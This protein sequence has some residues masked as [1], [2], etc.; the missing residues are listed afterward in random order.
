MSRIRN[1]GHVMAAALVLLLPTACLGKG[2]KSAGT[3]VETS[4]E[5]GPRPPAEVKGCALSVD[6]LKKVTGLMAQGDGVGTNSECTYLLPTKAGAVGELVVFV[7][8]EVRDP[9]ALASPPRLYPDRTTVVIP[10]AGTGAFAFEADARFSDI[11]GYAMTNS[12]L[13]TVKW[14]PMAQPTKDDS[15]LV[16]DVIKAFV[17]RLAVVAPTGQTTETTLRSPQAPAPTAPPLPP[18]VQSDPVVQP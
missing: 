1:A 16:V 5:P 17:E 11:L 2:S 6:E 8:S 15:K 13:L 12:G 4:V 3:T 14:T 18:S 10:K 7:R 9:A